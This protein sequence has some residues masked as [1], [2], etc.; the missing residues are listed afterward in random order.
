MSKSF[1]T[2]IV[3]ITIFALVVSLFSGCSILQKLGIGEKLNDETHPVSFVYMDE[4]DA[5]KIAGKTPVKLYFTNE[6]NSKL[7]A[8]I[9]YIKLDEKKNDPESLATEIMQ[10]LIKG[11]AE[12]T[13]LIATIPKDTKLHSDIKI[14]DKIATVDLSKEFVENHPGG[15]EAEKMTIY[16][17]VNSLTQ[18]KD[19]EKVQFKIEGQV[20]DRYKGN[21]KFDVPFPGSPSL[22][23]KEPPVKGRESS[24]EF[25]EEKETPK[26]DVDDTSEDVEDVSGDVKETIG[27]DEQEILE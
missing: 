17:I 4:V 16:S 8:E 23:S 22:N 11:P 6:D 15:K 20:K 2:K 21:F 3:I 1:Y 19:I 24:V 9:R 12:G 25:S 14:K 7:L 27:E 26:D 5:A 18:I 13:N 10:Q